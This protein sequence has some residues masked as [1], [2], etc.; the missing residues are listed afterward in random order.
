MPGYYNL[1]RTRAWSSYFSFQ[2]AE[3]RKPE[4]NLGV[5]F[6]ADEIKQGDPAQADVNARYFFDAPCQGLWTSTGRCTPG[7]IYF[8]L[9]GLPD[10]PDRTDVAGC[11]P[12]PRTFRLPLLWAIPSTSGTAQTSSEG[13]LAISLTAIPEV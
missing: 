6:L 1:R 8:Y 4:I 12:L 10:R 13:T 2:V 11:V 3:Y 7:P 5:E 9:P